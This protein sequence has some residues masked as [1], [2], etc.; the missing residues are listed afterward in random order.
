M[1]VTSKHRHGTAWLRPHT[2]RRT[3]LVEYATMMRSSPSSGACRLPLHQLHHQGYIQPQAYHTPPHLRHLHVHHLEHGV[4]HVVV[5]WPAGGHVVVSHRQLSLQRSQALGRVWEGGAKT[6]RR[7]D[8]GGLMHE[9]QREGDQQKKATAMLQTHMQLPLRG[10]SGWS[11]MQQ[12]TA[13][14][15]CS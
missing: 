11:S 4:K 6:E 8:A 10:N 2:L 7:R 15:S 13:S 14:E 1:C 5:G 9:Q 3:L 12:G